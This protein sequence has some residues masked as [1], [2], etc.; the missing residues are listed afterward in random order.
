MWGQRGDK[1]WKQR[2]PFH[3]K[4]DLSFTHAKWGPCS[5]VQEHNLIEINPSHFTGMECNHSIPVGMEALISEGMEWPFHSGRN[6]MP[7]Y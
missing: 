2:L 3:Y 6:G 4:A 1:I 7:F 5:K